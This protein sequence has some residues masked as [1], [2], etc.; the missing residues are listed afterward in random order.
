MK[1]DS[2][3][4]CLSDFIYAATSEG[5]PIGNTGTV[6]DI[7]S[8]AAFANGET[9]ATATDGLT[10]KEIFTDDIVEGIDAIPYLQIDLSSED[11]HIFNADIKSILERRFNSRER[12]AL[13]VY[14]L[15]GFLHAAHVYQ[16]HNG[17]AA[18][19]NLV[20]A[21]REN[22]LLKPGTWGR[23]AMRVLIG[24]FEDC[25]IDADYMISGGKLT[26]ITVQPLVIKRQG[27]SI[28]RAA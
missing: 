27:A 16:S 1:Y 7:I 19:S 11:V 23:D 13:L 4:E 25:L 22:P 17:L 20:A 9:S 8:S 5:G 18:G 15:F 28:K 21:L 14:G 10:V 12:L 24:R 6:C 26:L 3:R 2:A